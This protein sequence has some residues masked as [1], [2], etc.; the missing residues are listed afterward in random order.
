M[1]QISPVVFERQERDRA[2]VVHSVALWVLSIHFVDV[3][4]SRYKRVL[5]STS[6][7]ALPW[8]IAAPLAE[9]IL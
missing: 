9:A 2:P 7:A 6:V 3:N 8:T 1:I 5:K 4:C